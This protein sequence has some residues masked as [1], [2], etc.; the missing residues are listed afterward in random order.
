MQIRGLSESTKRPEEA[1]SCS[2]N[3]TIPFGAVGKNRRRIFRQSASLAL[4][5]RRVPPIRM[6]HL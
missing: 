1:A 5:S 6:A 4:S 2:A 3:P